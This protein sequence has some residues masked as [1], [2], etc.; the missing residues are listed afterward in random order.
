MPH[1]FAPPDN[2]S[3]KYSAG[4]STRQL[5]AARLPCFILQGT[6]VWLKRIRRENDSCSW[7]E[8]QLVKS[9]QSLGY[10]PSHT[11]WHTSYHSEI[12]FVEKRSRTPLHGRPS[13]RRWHLHVVSTRFS[14][15]ARRRTS[16]RTYKP[17]DKHVEI[18]ARP[19]TERR[20][21][22]TLILC[23]CTVTTLF[24]LLTF[25]TWPLTGYT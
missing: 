25:R 20:E 2:V 7:D 5:H 12:N 18:R 11:H 17:L 10:I 4:N 21:R 6:T 15:V 13:V 22:C 24:Q 1:L 8:F 19:Q 14:A 23:M 9:K 3:F 16:T